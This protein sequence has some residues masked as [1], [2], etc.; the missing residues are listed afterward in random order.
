[1]NLHAK[2]DIK[3]GPSRGHLL[4][5]LNWFP[6]NGASP[7]RRTPK[8]R[9][10]N[11]RA[12][13]ALGSATTLAPQPMPHS[14]RLHPDSSPWPKLRSAVPRPPAPFEVSTCEAKGRGAPWKSQR[15]GLLGVST[16]G[17]SQRK[18][19]PRKGHRS[20]ERPDWARHDVE[21][22]LKGKPKG[23]NSDCL[24][25]SLF[26]ARSKIECSKHM[27][28][29]K[30]PP[31][32]RTPVPS[33]C[34]GNPQKKWS[35]RVPCFNVETPQSPKSPQPSLRIA[36]AAPTCNGSV[37]ISCRPLLDAWMAIG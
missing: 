28:E 1:M 16:C 19:A 21:I 10:E 7:A 13:K 25:R 15:A 36:G 18:K 30:A 29:S 23:P 31:H 11:C 26:Q 20:L 3:R 33:K 8:T 4:G 22:W 27:A 35:W 5:T 32:S 2:N 14:A 12:R 17:R 37:L 9:A 34:T 24:S 6:P